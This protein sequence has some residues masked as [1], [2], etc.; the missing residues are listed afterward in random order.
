MKDRE[1]EQ[2]DYRINNTLW[3]GTINDYGLYDMTGDGVPELLLDM[4]DGLMSGGWEMYMYV[5]GKVK[6]IDVPSWAV[7]HGPSH[8]MANGMIGV[9]H[10]GAGV[11]YT[12]YKYRS[13]GNI[14]KTKF[15]ITGPDDYYFNDKKVPKEEY[16]KLTEYYLTEFDKGADIE[17]MPYFESIVYN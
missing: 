3:Y 9:E 16:D 5:N 17:W 13:D 6:N 8:I 12:F 1:K 10:H 15:A 7:Q 11:Y 14:T 4:R 2:Y